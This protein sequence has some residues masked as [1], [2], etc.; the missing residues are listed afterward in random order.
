MTCR[1]KT[2]CAVP[3]LLRATSMKRS[4]ASLPNPASSGWL[5]PMER[6]DVTSGLKSVFCCVVLCRSAL[7]E[8]E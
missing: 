3:T 8:T 5:K 6:R 2:S 7:M 4:L 1:R